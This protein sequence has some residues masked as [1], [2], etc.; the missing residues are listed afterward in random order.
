MIAHAGGGV[1]ELVAMGLALGAIFT[2]LQAKRRIG[3]G[4]RRSGTVLVFLALAIGFLA[5]FI[6]I[7]IL[8]P[9]IAQGRPASTATI[10]VLAPRDGKVVPGE[11]LDIQI[12]I[13][14]GRIVELA[15]TDLR[16]D[17]GHLHLSI[18]GKLL[19]MRMGFSQ[20]VDIG[21]LDRGRHLLMVEYVASDHAPFNPRVIDRT[22]FQIR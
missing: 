12:R 17:E 16:P 3:V 13:A 8:R 19:S 21:D 11:S 15:S 18:D 1:D 2:G 10:E 6:P 14:G 5:F 20:R 9:N 22:T 7:K 4:E